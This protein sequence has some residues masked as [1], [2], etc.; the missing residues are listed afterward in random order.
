[1]CPRAWFGCR[2]P[3]I[4][5]LILIYSRLTSAKT[6]LDYMWWFIG[7]RCAVL[8]FTGAFRILWW[9][10]LVV[11]ALTTHVFER[12]G[13]GWHEIGSTTPQYRNHSIPLTCIWCS[14]YHH[15]PLCLSNMIPARVVAGQKQRKLEHG[16]F[17]QCSEAIAS[18]KSVMD[19]GI[20]L[21]VNAWIRVKQI[22]APDASAENWMPAKNKW[23]EFADV[24]SDPGLHAEATDRIH[25]PRPNQAFKASTP[26]TALLLKD[27][28]LY[29]TDTEIQPWD[30]RV[31]SSRGSGAI[32]ATCWVVS[33]AC[34]YSQSL[35]AIRSVVLV[36]THDSEWPSHKQI[37]ESLQFCNIVPSLRM[38]RSIACSFIH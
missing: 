29:R 22:G 13:H 28:E 14:V 17:K 24:P 3:L 5:N 36:V 4:E 2:E 7:C 23:Y 32:V 1:M 30:L 21:S 27:L 37:A 16:E 8:S 34:T 12:V 10:P 25:K 9:Y 20:T 15:A 33:K 26:W 38:I 35:P 6:V 31:G 11:V 19:V 18:F